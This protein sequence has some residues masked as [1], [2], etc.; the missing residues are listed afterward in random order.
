[1]RVPKCVQTEMS[2][3][4]LGDRISWEHRQISGSSLVETVQG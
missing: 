1:M 2:V 3:V 4:L